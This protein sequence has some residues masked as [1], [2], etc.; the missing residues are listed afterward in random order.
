MFTDIKEALIMHFSTTNMYD[1]AVKR[2]NMSLN[3]VF[4]EIRSLGLFHIKV[5]LTI[6]N[7]VKDNCL[8]KFW[9]QLSG[10]GG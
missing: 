2:H 7:C 8:G 1:L 3:F 6:K 9:G 10:G 5:T 4:H